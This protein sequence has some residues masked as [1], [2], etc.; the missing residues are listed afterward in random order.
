ME[1]NAGTQPLI[2]LVKQFE[3]LEVDDYQ[4]AYTWGPDDIE[5]LF[6]DLKECVA[7]ADNH[8]FG[9]LIIQQNPEGM[10]KVVDGQQRLTTT[11]I[12]VAAIRDELNSLETKMLK[13]DGDDPEIWVTQKANEYL[14]FNNRA[15]QPRFLANRLIRSYMNESVLAA[16]KEREIVDVPS[17]AITKKF[18]AATKQIRELVRVDL[19]QFDTEEAKLRRINNLLDALLERFQVLRVVTNTVG[20]SLDIFMTLNARGV[21]LAASDL[22]RGEIISLLGSRLSESDQIAL[23]SKMLNQWKTVIERVEDVETYMRHYL[24]FTGDAKV[25][26]NKI[27]KTV[28]EK[29]DPKVEG[30]PRRTQLEK[31]EAARKFWDEFVDDSKLYAEVLSTQLGNPEAQ[32][33]LELLEGL[34]KSHRPLAMAIIREAEDAKQLESSLKLLNIL[35]YRWTISK[36]NAQ[37]FEDQLQTWARAL[38]KNKDF[39]ALET[40]MAA[41]LADLKMVVL[42]F[43]QE[44]GDTSFVTR[45]LLHGINHYLSDGA[46]EIHL[47]SSLQL[48]HIA[49]QKPTASWISDVLPDDP[50]NEAKY[51]KLVK[52]AGNLALLDW[53]LN[54]KAQQ[55]DFVVKTEDYYSK[56]TVFVTRDLG[57]LEYDEWMADDISNRTDWLAEMVDALWPMNDASCEFTSFSKWAEENV[58]AES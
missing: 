40:E 7:D 37:T 45:G 9:T 56:S 14:L 48:E 53:K 44:K 55:K 51:K 17:N 54:I 2:N 58:T 22:V 38:L 15:S 25:Q 27:L 3:R 43:L 1:N 31:I 39:K 11:F 8:F 16:T 49:P 18:I 30:K 47:N 13:G 35:A 6:D 36:G 57:L 33:R 19:K 46:N 42:H 12:L 29:I 32:F 34:G 4:R 24:L 28:L 41:T 20:E 50:A 52:Q 5:A 26:K 21:P 23:H 10:A